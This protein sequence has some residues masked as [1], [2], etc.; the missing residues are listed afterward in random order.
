MTIH[1]EHDADSEVKEVEGKL[2]AAVGELIGDTGMKL[3]GE[4]KQVQAGAMKIGEHVEEGVKSLAQKVVD[5]GQD[6]EKKMK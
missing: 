5:R 6:S 1:E 2:Q 4:A 3:K